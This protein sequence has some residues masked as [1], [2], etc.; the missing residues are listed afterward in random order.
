[1][2]LLRLALVDECQHRTTQRLSPA[3]LR[4]VPVLDR[5]GKPTGEYTFQGNL[6][7]K[8]LEL[9]GKELGMFGKRGD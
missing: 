2:R 3:D 5:Q 6:A 1:M 4:P 7:N 8:A 9:L